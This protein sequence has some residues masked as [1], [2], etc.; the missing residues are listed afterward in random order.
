MNE[1]VDRHAKVKGKATSKKGSVKQEKEAALRSLVKS[2]KGV[3]VVGKE[4]KTRKMGKLV[5][6]VK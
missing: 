3:T 1:T 2:G 5:K 4:G 6:K